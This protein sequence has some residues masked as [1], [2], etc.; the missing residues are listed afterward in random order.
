M[1]TCSGHEMLA[2][3]LK[4]KS[5]VFHGSES[6]DAYVLILDFCERFH[7]LGIVHQHGVEFMTFQLKGEIKHWWRGYTERRSSIFSPH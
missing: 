4:I 2:K 3:F 5:H 6:E 1:M 7:K